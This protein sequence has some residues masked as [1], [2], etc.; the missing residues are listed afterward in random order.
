[1]RAIL[2]A[3]FQGR[4]A[5]GCVGPDGGDEDG[6][7]AGEVGELGFVE[8]D[9][10]DCWG[11]VSGEAFQKRASLSEQLNIRGYAAKSFEIEQ[12]GSLTG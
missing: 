4:L 8:V 10:L 5:V 1:M 9:D 7:L 2:G 11:S 3:G 6:G 12:I